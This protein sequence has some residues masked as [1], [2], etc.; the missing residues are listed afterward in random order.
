MAEQEDHDDSIYTLAELKTDMCW[1]KKQLA[2]H[3]AHHDK[4]LYWVIGAMGTI[5]IGLI[6][7]A[8]L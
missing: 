2:N 3:L 4:Y 8:L 7:N 5:G 1:V 6:L